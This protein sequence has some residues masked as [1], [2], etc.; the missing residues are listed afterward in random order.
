MSDRRD[1]FKDWLEREIVTAREKAISLARDK[2]YDWADLSASKE[3]TL[4]EVLREYNRRQHP[5]LDALPIVNCPKCG[6][7]MVGK[8]ELH[9]FG[10]GFDQ[11]RAEGD[12]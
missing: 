6:E 9:C 2:C 8:Q 4:N 3:K 11:P 10:C 1:A 7:I 5:A 12:Q